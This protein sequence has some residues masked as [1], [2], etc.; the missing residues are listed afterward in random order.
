MN[1]QQQIK[2]SE[3]QL[4]LPTSIERMKKERKKRSNM[5][6][7]RRATL[8]KKA[9]ELHKECD[10][11]DV[12]FIVRDRRSNKIWQYSNGY[13]PPTITEMVR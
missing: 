3:Q 8:I 4:L 1:Q 9:Q 6:S 12:F 7:K 13:S 11:I 5:F 10:D 2:Y